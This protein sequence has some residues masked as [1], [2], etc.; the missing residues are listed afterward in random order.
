MRGRAILFVLVAGIAGPAAPAAIPGAVAAAGVVIVYHD[1]CDSLGKG[2]VTLGL[3]AGDLGSPTTSWTVLVRAHS[4][5]G[6]SAHAIGVCIGSGT[7]GAG[8]ALT[9]CIG[10]VEGGRFGPVAVCYPGPRRPMPHSVAY[11]VP[12]VVDGTGGTFDGT[13]RADLYGTA[14]DEPQNLCL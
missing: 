6:C 7:L 12:V 3:V 11:D 14:V 13:I 4:Q 9:D 8:L 10:S 5:D 2:D 1:V